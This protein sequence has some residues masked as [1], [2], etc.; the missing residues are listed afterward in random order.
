MAYVEAVEEGGIWVSMADSG[1]TWRGIT[2]IP[3]SD[4]PKN[5]YPLNWYPQESLNG[6]NHL[7]YTADGTP[8][9]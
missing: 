8:I 9:V 4:D 7:D 6:F 2:Y 1:H 5:P 3:R